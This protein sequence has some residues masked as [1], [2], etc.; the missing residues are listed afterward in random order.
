MTGNKISL[1]LVETQVQFQFGW[2]TAREDLWGRPRSPSA[3]RRNRLP[4][5]ISIMMANR[6]WLQPPV[7]SQSVWVTAQAGSPDR[8]R[9]PWPGRRCQ[10]LWEI[11][12]TMGFRIW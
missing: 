8:L 2:E 11:L 4:L 5:A 7:Q 1:L 12:I 10:S 6:I 3:A 9:L